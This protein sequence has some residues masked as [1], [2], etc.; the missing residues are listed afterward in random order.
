MAKNFTKSVFVLGRVRGSGGVG[1]ACR[2]QRAISSITTKILSTLCFEMESLTSLRLDFS[3][4]LVEH[5]ASGIHI[6]THTHVYK[7]NA[8]MHPCSHTYTHAHKCTQEHAY[9][10]SHGCF[11]KGWSKMQVAWTEH[12]IS[13]FSGTLIDTSRHSTTP[14]H[15]Q[16]DHLGSCAQ[17]LAHFYF[18][19]CEQLPTHTGGKWPSPRET[20][21]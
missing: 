12:F 1:D 18:R 13:M 6:H 7:H 19:Q 17:A 15:T 14:R 8:H 9:S 16:R 21:G 3:A 2:S 5:W 4:K 20:R 11:M 10:Q